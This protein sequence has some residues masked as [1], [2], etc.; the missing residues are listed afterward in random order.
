MAETVGND[1]GGHFFYEQ[2]QCDHL[3]AYNT[4]YNING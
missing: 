4:E 1:N 2:L 3:R